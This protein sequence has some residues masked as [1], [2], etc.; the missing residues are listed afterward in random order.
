MIL[1]LVTGFQGAPHVQTV[2]AA[3]DVSVAT[4][5]KKNSAAIKED[6]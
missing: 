6:V 3:G 2:S 4:I 5:F 1:D